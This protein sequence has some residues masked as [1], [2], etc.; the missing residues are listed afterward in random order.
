M[1]VS[2]IGIE[3]RD[4]KWRV[5]LIDR[6]AAARLPGAG[7]VARVLDAADRAQE[8]QRLGDRLSAD[9]VLPLVIIRADLGRARPDAVERHLR[10]ILQTQTSAELQTALRELA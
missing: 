2:R 1:D 10:R 3:A 4:L 7:R 8:A 9:F 5:Q 6:R